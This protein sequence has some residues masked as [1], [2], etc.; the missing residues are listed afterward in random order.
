MKLFCSCTNKPVIRCQQRKRATTR[1]Q[2]QKVN[3]MLTLGAALGA[4]LRSDGR[5]RQ[6]GLGRASCRRSGLVLDDHHLSLGP[7]RRPLGQS[8]EKGESRVG[9]IRCKT[10]MA[11]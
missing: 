2:K 6:G 1:T 7:L 3:H 8:P 9:Q 5:I 10:G 4:A 11:S